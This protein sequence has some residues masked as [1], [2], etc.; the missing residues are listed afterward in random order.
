MINK[1]C[2]DEIQDILEVCMEDMFV[3]YGE[4]KPH[5]S[6]LAVV[7]TG[8]RKFNMRLNLKKC[9]FRVKA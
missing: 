3:K 7:F 6:N 8:A 2:K 4:E 1:I 9:M 5:N